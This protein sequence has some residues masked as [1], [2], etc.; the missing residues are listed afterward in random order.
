MDFKE[1]PYPSTEVYAAVTRQL[2]R[3]VPLH[4]N[5]PSLVPAYRFIQGVTHIVS[6]SFLA[7]TYKTQPG[8]YI[9]EQ[10]H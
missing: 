3:K 8:S 9:V 5:E 4:P 7:G 6:K 2:I 1:K 10:V